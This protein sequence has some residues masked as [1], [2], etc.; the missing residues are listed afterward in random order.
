MNE[1]WDIGQNLYFGPKFALLAQ[2]K[3]FRKYRNSVISYLFICTSF[4]QKTSKHLFSTLI[5]STFDQSTVPSHS[6]ACSATPDVVFF[7]SFSSKSFWCC[8]SLVLTLHPVSPIYIFPQLQCIYEKQSKSTKRK[9]RKTKNQNKTKQQRWFLY[10][11][12]RDLAQNYKKFFEMLDT[13]QSSNPA[14]TLE[15]F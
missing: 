13:R 9:E 7:F 14:L 6:H 1:S 10:R 5:V 8:C 4:M 3:N 15:R 2:N 11:G 12:Y